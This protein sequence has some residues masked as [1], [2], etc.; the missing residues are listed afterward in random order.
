[1]RFDIVRTSSDYYR[2]E[3]PCDGAFVYKKKRVSK[4]DDQD[5]LF[6]AVEVNSFEELMK[7]VDIEGQVVLSCACPETN[8]L[9]RIEIYDNYRE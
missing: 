1:M 3:K 7:I 2:E 4:L 9:P 8:E 5:C 6:W